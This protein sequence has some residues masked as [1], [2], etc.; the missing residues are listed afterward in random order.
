MR[1]ERNAHRSTSNISEAVF[2][3][4]RGPYPGQDRP[5]LLSMFYL[6]IG[7]RLFLW[8]WPPFTRELTA[9]KTGTS[10]SF[11]SLPTN[12][13]RKSLALI[14]DVLLPRPSVHPSQT[15]QA[16]INIVYLDL[17]LILH[18]SRAPAEEEPPFPAS[19]EV[20]IV[21]ERG[22]AA[23]KRHNEAESEASQSAAYTYS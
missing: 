12:R 23:V 5:L 13:R 7:L 8:P 10:P 15:S 14:D 1:R 16:A 9:R 21:Q 18:G 4:G 6:Q 20:V 19:N 17:A 11:L 2:C 22:V 3:R